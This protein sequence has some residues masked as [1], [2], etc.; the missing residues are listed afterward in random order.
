MCAQKDFRA[1]GTFGASSAPILHWNKQ[2][3]HT[4][5]NE[6]PHDPNHLGVSSGACKTISEPMVC[7]VQTVHLSSVKISTI[8]KRTEMSFCLSLITL[9]YHRV[10]LKLFLS[11]WYVPR[12][13]CTYLAS[14]LGLSPNGPK[15]ASTWTSSSTNSIGCIR[16]DF[17]ACGTL[18]K[19]VHLSST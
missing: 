9:E 4:D 7:S 2:Y 18:T 3:I 16:N 15:W 14:R 11:L 17:L 1:C 10:H 13:P 8:S 5:W 19:P 6:I 12:K